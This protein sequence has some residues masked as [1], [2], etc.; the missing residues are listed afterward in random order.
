MNHFSIKD[1]E[2]LT[3][4]KSHTLRI[5]EQRYGIP[6]PKRTSTNIRYYDGDDLKLLLNVSMLNRNGLKISK[7]TKLPK[8]ELERMALER[9]LTDLDTDSQV[10]AMISAMFSLDEPGFDKVLSS[11][12]VRNG[13]ERTMIDLFFPFL[14]RVGVLWQTGQ[15]NPAYE[16]FMSNLIR[17]KMIVAID[18]LN[19]PPAKAAKKFVLFLPESETHEL[20]LLFANYIVR[21]RG[22]QSLYLGQNLAYTDLDGLMTQY[23]PE[24]LMTV[25]TATPPKQTTQEFVTK[26]GERFKKQ[27]VVL[28]G[29]QITSHTFLRFTSNTRV[30][31]SFED[32]VNFVDGI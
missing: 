1:I 15:V 20:G 28:T 10:D 9:A 24:F 7:L 13:L 31:N 17:Q 11:H 6:H 16:H 18:S 25:V 14:K 4:I 21:S 30:I 32:F 2:N 8:D 23:A 19:V 29:F 22:H 3:G 5:W 27:T 26:L 12:L